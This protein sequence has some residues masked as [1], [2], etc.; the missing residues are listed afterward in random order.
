LT[1]L[2]DASLKDTNHLMASAPIF[3]HF[4]R[5]GNQSQKQMTEPSQQDHINPTWDKTLKNEFEFCVTP[6]MLSPGQDRHQLIRFSLWHRFSDGTNQELGFGNIEVKDL[7]VKNYITPKGTEITVPITSAPQEDG[8]IKETSNCRRFNSFLVFS[9]S[10][11]GDWSA[12]LEVERLKDIE[13][14]KESHLKAAK[15][16]KGVRDH[17]NIDFCDQCRLMLISLQKWNQNVPVISRSSKTQ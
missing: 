3:P 4:E 17:W 2:S 15:I 16:A 9:I 8:K 1:V 12:D 11:M 5:R 7:H 10:F 6:H 13:K 14:A